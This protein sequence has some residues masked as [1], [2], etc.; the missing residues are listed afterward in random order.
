MIVFFLNFFLLMAGSSGAVP[1]GEVQASEDGQSLIQ[2]RDYATH[3]LDV[4][5]DF[6]SIIRH[7]IL[8]RFQARRT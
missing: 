1:F 6:G 3:R 5:W 8:F 2:C 7:W 4:V